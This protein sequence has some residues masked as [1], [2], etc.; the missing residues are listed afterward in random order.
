MMTA[1]EKKRQAADG[2]GEARTSDG[3]QKEQKMDTVWQYRKGGARKSG[4]C[5]G[6]RKGRATKATEKRDGW[7]E[8][9]ERIFK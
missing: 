5:V 7:D 6:E 1:K 3:G 9:R 2:G 8:G 4:I